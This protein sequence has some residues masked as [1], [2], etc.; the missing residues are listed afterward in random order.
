MRNFNI[1]HRKDGRWEGR[2]PHGKRKNGKR[3]FQYFF[4]RSRE[5]VFEKMKIFRSEE[6]DNNCSL[7]VQALINEWLST[8]KHVNNAKVVRFN[9]KISYYSSTST[10][11]NV[12]RRSSDSIPAS[13]KG[14]VNSAGCIIIGK[15]GTASS[16]EYAKF[17]KAV[18]IVGSSSSGSSKYSS[19]VSG[20]III[21]RTYAYSYLSNVGYSSG[22]IST[23][24]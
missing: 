6:S 17:I 22:A 14:W 2:I 15:A 16:G 1:Y 8:A 10:G 12:H 7:T 9:S 18:G 4:G 13:S 24:G 5:Q 3:K 21:D 23:I 11:I 20:Q 19:S